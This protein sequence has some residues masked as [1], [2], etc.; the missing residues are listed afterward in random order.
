MVNIPEIETTISKN[1]CL[2]ERITVVCEL[3]PQTLS[4]IIDSGKKWDVEEIVQLLHQILQ[5]LAYLEEN[6]IVHRALNP[7]NIMFGSSGEAKLYN[8]GL[9]YMTGEGNF[10]SFPIG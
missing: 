1:I 8:Y 4:Q 2:I 9:F 6:G 3:F 5:A 10:I 7:E